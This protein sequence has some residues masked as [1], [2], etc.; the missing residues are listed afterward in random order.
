MHGV[1]HVIDDIPVAVDELTEVYDTATMCQLIRKKYLTN[2]IVIYPDASGAS[3]KTS[4]TKTDFGIIQD[5]GFIIRSK[6]VNPG[7]E[8]RIKT[9]NRMFAD[10]KGNIRYKVN[11]LKCPVYVEALER[12][13]RDK[14]EQPDK[15]S[16]FDH[17]TEAGGYFIYYAYPPN[18]RKGQKAL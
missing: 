10:G 14:N 6:K 5:A 16:G 11:V 1:V 18:K 13:G 12:M 17:I 15:H 3:R 2:K 8:D 4:A 9:M 7:V